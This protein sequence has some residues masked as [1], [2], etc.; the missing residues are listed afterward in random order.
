MQ[1][2]KQTISVILLTLLLTACSGPTERMVK[3]KD[4]DISGL[5]NKYLKIVDG[6][7]QFT[8][9]GDDAFITVQF[10]LTKK[11]ENELCRKKHPQN[12][13][14]NAIGENGNIFDTGTYG[15]VASRSEM[16]KLKDFLN[17]GVLNDKVRISFNWNYYGVSEEEGKPIF[18]KATSFEIIDNTFGVCDEYSDSDVHW[19]DRSVDS[20]NSSKTS[21]AVTSNKSNDV[22][23]AEWDKALD[24]Y[25]EYID[26][27]AKL[28]KKVQDGD[29]SAMSE[30]PKLVE[31]TMKFSEKMDNAGDDLSTAQMTRFLELQNKFTTAMQNLN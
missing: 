2:T 10:E 31:K 26:Q 9:N 15:F 25:E 17:N 14:L 4:A 5:S 21:S 6:D 19:D 8:N 1:K 28:M 30:Y 22:G 27:Y 18:E 16:G 7:Y 23:S 13:R 11:P 24:S 20:N 12:I 3:A 29:A